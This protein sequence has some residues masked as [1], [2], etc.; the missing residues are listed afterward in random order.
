STTGP[1]SATNTC[2]GNVVVGGSCSISVTFT[3]RNVGMFSGTLNLSDSSA[4]SPQKVTLQGRVISYRPPVTASGVKADL[5]LTNSAA[6]PAPTGQ[7]VVGTRV[8]ELVDSSRKD[9]YD[10]TR[11]SR[12]LAIRLWYP[13]ST[14]SNQPCTPADYASPKVWEYFG[15]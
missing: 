3:A 5:A 4:D 14:H 15:Q 12:E 7:N 6:V 10:A 1:F 2:G 9:P 11:N 13:V 8:L